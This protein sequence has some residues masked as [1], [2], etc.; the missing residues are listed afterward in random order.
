MMYAGSKNKLVQTAEL[1]KVKWKKT[2][3]VGILGELGCSCTFISRVVTGA[4]VCKDRLSDIK[5]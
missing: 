2:L 4:P 5:F 1:T 3:G